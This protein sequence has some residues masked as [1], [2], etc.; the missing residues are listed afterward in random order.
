MENKIHANLPSQNINND[1]SISEENQKK[2]VN[3][4]VLFR[5]KKS[6]DQIHIQTINNDASSS[7]N[8]RSKIKIINDTFLEW[9]KRSSID[10]YVKMFEYESHVIR[11][12]WLTVCLASISLTESIYN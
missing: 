8:Q 12:I 9:S 11:F 1:E 2:A 7:E 6:S 5:E 3:K 10:G 4:I